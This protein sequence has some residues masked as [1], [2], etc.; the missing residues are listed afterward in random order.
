MGDMRCPMCGKSNPSELENCQFCDARLTPLSASTPVDSQPIEVGENPVK[1]DTSEFEKVKPAGGDLVHAGEAPTKKNTAE[2]EPKLPSWLRS[3]REDQDSDEGKSKEDASPDQGLPLGPAPTTSSDSSGDLPDWLPGLGKAAS[4]DKEEVPDWLASLGGEEA[5]TSAPVSAPTPEPASNATGGV[6]PVPGRGRLSA[7]PGGTEDWL[8]GLGSEPQSVTPETAPQGGLQGKGESLDWLDSLISEPAAPGTPEQLVAPQV[9]EGMPDWLS[10]LSGISEENKPDSSQGENLPDWLNQL[11]EKAIDSEPAPRGDEGTAAG[12]DIPDWLSNFGSTPGT[13][14]A[15]TGES[16]PEWQ[17]DLEAKTGPESA[18]PAPIFSSEPPP[19]VVVPVPERGSAARDETPSWLSQFQADVN[20]AEELEAK[21]EQFEA[22][23]QPPA[24]KK[25]TGPLPDW[26]AGI[27]PSTTPSDGTPALI[28]NNESTAPEE[29]DDAAFSME[30]PDWLSKLEPE[31]AA[32]KTPEG[33][34][35][36][37]TP[38]NLEVSELPSWVQAMRPVESVVAEA[39]PTPQEDAQVTEQSGPLAGLHGVLPVGLGLGP[40]RKPPAY[41]TNLQVTEG[42]Q[43]YAAAFERLISSETQPQAAKRTRLASNRLWRWLIA[44]LLILAVGL[45]LSTRIPVTQASKLQPPEMVKAFTLIGSLPSNA[46]VL[47]V[48]DYDPALSGELEAAAAPLMDHLLLQGPRLA[49]ISTSPTGPALAERLLH[50]TS[51]SPLVAGHNYQAG[52]QYVNLGYLAGGSS[53]VLY[54]AISPAKAAPFTLDG[55]Q[56]WQLPPL[57]GIQ[58]LSDFAAI[59]VL[60]DN[61][62]SGRV[63]IEQAGSTIG[64]TP[65]LMVISAQAEPMILPYYDS[66]QIKGLVTGLAGGEAYGQTFVRP[67]A[68][69]GL[70]QRYWNSFSAGTL[71]AEIL[72]L[73]GALWSAVTGWRARRDK[74]G[75]V[76]VPFRGEGV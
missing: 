59:I 4:K 52:Q 63:W 40:L 60:T 74:S 39:K 45:P 3:L 2:L 38:E 71:V 28:A 22:A 57:Q 20:A 35:K 33:D 70:A 29:K 66:G 49:L 31:Q 67:D 25:G 6:V 62:D 51:A 43:R 34:A 7:D 65:I 14:E 54:F 53:G 23:P 72:I 32:E 1:K 37:S 44:G 27:T 8:A 21:K 16:L 10:G 17:S 61:A 64:N 11:K 50:D 15:A 47:V 13:P 73:V 58:K 30:I 55:Q 42:Q 75:E 48:F 69:T 68:Q 26:L 18:A 19:S 36:T 76:P 46:P 24:K 9:N 41:S 5:G 56:A 12:P